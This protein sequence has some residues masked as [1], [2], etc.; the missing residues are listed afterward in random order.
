MLVGTVGKKSVDNTGI[1]AFHTGVRAGVQAALV[2][3]WMNPPQL[4]RGKS[5]VMEVEK[6]TIVGAVRRGA[7]SPKRWLGRH[8]WW[9]WWTGTR[10][11]SIGH[12]TG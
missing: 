10:R 4:R 1:E 2:A 5:D 6:V 12:S 9:N 8:S 7:V 11:F 3:S